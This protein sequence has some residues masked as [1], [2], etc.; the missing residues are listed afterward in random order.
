MDLDI[1]EM[2]HNFPLHE[3][4][5][6]FCGI[7][8]SSF[9]NDIFYLTSNTKFRW[10]RLWF[11][12]RP[13]PYF[14]V[15]HLALAE[16]QAKGNHLD[17]TNPFYWST[18]KLNLPCSKNFDPT[19]PWIYKWN[20]LSNNLAGDVISFVDDFRITGYSVENC[21]QCGRRLA[22]VLQS[23]G[24]QE[25]ARKRSSPTLNA[26]AWAG[27]VSK[28]EGVVTKTITQLKWNK[29]KV[30]LKGISLEMG[31]PDHPR[32]LLHKN[33]ER[34]RGYFNHLCL[35]YDNV[36]PLMRGMHNS[37]DSW[38]DK[39]NER[40]W[41][42]DE[43]ESEW[44]DVLSFYLESG[45]ISEETY[46]QLIQSQD[47]HN[48]TPKYVLPAPRLFGD[49]K[50]LETMFQEET[51][52]QY[53]VRFQR[54]AEIIYGFADASGGGLGSMFQGNDEDSINIRIGV[55]S[56]TLSKERSS[57]WREFKNVVE[58]VLTEAR[59][60]RLFQ[61]VVFLFTDNSTVESAMVKGNTPIEALFEL[62]E[63]LK[64]AEMK[65]SFMLHVIHVSGS[66][67]IYQGTDGVSRGELT[68]NTLP[69]QPIRLQ[70]PLNLTC[71]ERS[72]SLKQWISSWI[73]PK[74]VYL[75]T[76]QWYVEGH[77][78]RYNVKDP[79]SEMFTYESATYVWTPPPAVGDV[80]LEQIRYARLKRQS[81]LHVFLIPKL[82]YA[83]FRRQL[84]KTMDIVL[85]LPPR[86]D[87]WPD[88][89]HEPLIIAFLFPFIRFKPWTVKHTPKLC[90][91]GRELQRLWKEKRLDRRHILCQL[92]LE[93]R[94]F[95]TLPEHLVRVMLFFE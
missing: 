56:S 72:A 11:G 51:P 92:L 69:R 9:K 42:E 16:E 35:T 2:F 87:F 74:A 1:G 80:S 82:F 19:A 5:Q 36:T 88:S 25:A 65:Y 43:S 45:K 44:K 31:T 91:V 48:E 95:P 68:Q 62:V 3:N 76:S 58:A 22:S 18:I 64:G 15:R 47:N 49:I 83:L 75:S 34:A 77:D 67:M 39:R 6:A 12:F 70:V 7:N 86:F 94:K 90:S 24:I 50:I 23:L 17:P 63:T 46:D 73:G 13:S 84:F 26:D 71:L 55:W 14:A 4:I 29:A 59:K 93:G 54:V 21:W 85:F 38:R 60:G 52:A 37:L 41:K 8:L 27:C 78:L 57:N 20:N 53:P 79:T 30:Y 33:L 28:T 40:G 10:K 61:T 89:M 32:P 66:R 81:S